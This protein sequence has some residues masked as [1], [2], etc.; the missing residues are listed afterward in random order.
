MFS[1]GFQQ[2]YQRGLQNTDHIFFTKACHERLED[3]DILLTYA[4]VFGLRQ[5]CIA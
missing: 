3:V 1:F 4:V 2:A 5:K